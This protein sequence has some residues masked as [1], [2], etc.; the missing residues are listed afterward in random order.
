MPN[1]ALIGAAGY[2]APRHLQAIKSNGGTLVAALDPNDS[3]GILDSYFPDTAFFTEFER[4]DRH[5]EKLKRNGQKVDY[6]VVCSP[7]YLH[8]AHCRFGLRYGADVICEKPLVLNPWNVDAL[9]EM[10]AETGQ[11]IYNILQL[12]LHPSVIALRKKIQEGPKDKVYD[13]DLTYLTSRGNWYYASWKGNE[14]KSGG[15]AANIGI[16]FFD[17][18]LWIFGGL[19]EQEVHIRSHDRAAGHLTLERARIKWFLGI[20]YDLMP[21][22]LKAKGLRTYRSLEIEGENFEFSGGFTEL[23]DKSYAEILAEKGF[24]VKAV[25]AAIELVGQIRS[26]KVTEG[27]SRAHILVKKPHNIHPFTAK[28]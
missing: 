22:H 10:E 13:I 18:L 11:K 6:I 28:R 17:M 25:K 14:A 2:I 26:S 5:L 24:G 21:D 23:H 20:N 27:A 1:F 4:F 7:N 16:H 3:V 19:K 15:I 8:D 12:R 9:A